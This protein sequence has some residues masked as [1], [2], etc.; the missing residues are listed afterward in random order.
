MR[1]PDQYYTLE[2]AFIEAAKGATKRI[3]LPGGGTLD[4]RIPEGLADG[5]TIRLRGKGGP[6]MGGGPAGDALV[7]VSVPGPPSMA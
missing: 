5:Q 4:V 6:G 3:T 7:T 1:G 2:V